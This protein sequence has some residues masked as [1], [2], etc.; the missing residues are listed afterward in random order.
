MTKTVLYA[1]V[2]TAD[3]TVDHQKTA[4]EAKGYV[5]DEVVT[6]DGVSGSVSLKDRPQGKRLLDLLRR[7]DTLVVRW[8]D[9]L[10]RDYNDVTD[11]IRDFMR[12]GVIIKTIINDMEFDGS[13]TDPMGMALRDAM[14]TFMAGMAQAQLEAT[15]D[16]QRSG[17]AHAQT[18]EPEKFLG[19]KPTFDGDQLVEVMRL[20]G[21]GTSNSEIARK[22]GLVR[23]TIIRI[24]ADPA[25]AAQQVASWEQA[26]ELRKSPKKRRG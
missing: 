14:M 23:Q 24:K 18:K 25:K 9:R 4:A 17:I 8:V 13:R 2:S 10:G 26:E 15:K 16:A 5:F 6:D 1:R 21:L 7:G 12:K 19:R 22:T 20:L 3:Q 11:T